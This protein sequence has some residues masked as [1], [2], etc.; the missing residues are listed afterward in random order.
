M[1]QRTTDRGSTHSEKLAAWHAQFP[2][3]ISDP[4]EGADYI[5]AVSEE[6]ARG[7][8][9]YFGEEEVEKL[10][11]A[12]WMSQAAFPDGYDSREEWEESSNFC[13]SWWQECAEPIFPAQL[14]GAIQ[15]WEVIR[16]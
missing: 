7:E 15:A 6:Q 4:E 11:Y 2:K 13:E 12:G 3:F 16:R 10:E 9:P 5:L 14:L 1:T 8:I